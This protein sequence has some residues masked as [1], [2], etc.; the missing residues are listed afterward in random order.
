M[1]VAIGS[2]LAGIIFSSLRGSDKTTALTNVR[3]NGDFVISQLAKTVRN[4]RNFDGVST[5]DVS[6]TTDCVAANV[7]PTP[8]PIPY[9]FV[10][11]TSFDGQQTKF[12]CTSGASGTIS[13]NSASL[14]DTTLVS[15][16][17]CFFT[18]SKSTIVDFPTI[19]IYFALSTFKPTGVVNLFPEKKASINFQT[20]VT[21][22]NLNR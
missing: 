4:A 18:C 16:D 13:S 22:R 5:D 7:T 6:Y 2:I 3:E 17:S 19:G 14:L 11:I 10:K 15:L 12:S 8:T 9:K 21:I 20:T 1:I